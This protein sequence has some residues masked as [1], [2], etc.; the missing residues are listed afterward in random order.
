MKCNQISAIALSLAAIVASSSAFADLRFNGF[1]SIAGGM[2]LSDNETYLGYDSDISFKPETLFALQVSADLS[3]GLTA[4]AQILSQGSEDFDTEFAWAYLSYEMTDAT[5][6]RA[7]RLRIPLYLYS[8]FLDVGYAYPWVRP[9]SAMYNLPFANYEGISVLHTT[10]VGDWDVLLNFTAG[11]LSDT[12]FANVMPT[13][14]DV[15]NMLGLNVNATYDWFNVYA[16]YLRGDITIPL[17][18]VNDFSNLLQQLGVPASSVDK[19]RANDDAGSF[20]GFGFNIDYNN[21]LLTSEYSTWGADDSFIEESRDAWYVSAGYRFDTI[22][23]Y[24]QLEN[25][26]VDAE[27]GIT[28]SLPGTAIPPVG[29]P[30]DGVPI[31]LAAQGLLAQINREDTQIVSVGFRYDFHTNAAFKMQYSSVTDDFN[32]NNDA[33]LISVAVDLIF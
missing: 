3:D 32:N 15:D 8:D 9:S 4:T 24:V 16:S 1:A 23:P 19:L 13:Q 7:G 11:S 28:S 27:P 5:T 29:T 2:T 31:N 25:L 30:F 21:F 6:I 26:T 22:T 20:F 18:P 10:M 17:A 33:D 14:A 12:V